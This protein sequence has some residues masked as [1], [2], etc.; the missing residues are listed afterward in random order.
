[1]AYFWKLQFELESP[2]D[3]PP[4]SLTNGL[5]PRADFGF[6]TAAGQDQ[7]IGIFQINVDQILCALWNIFAALVGDRHNI[8]AIF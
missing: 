5:R 4:D 7:L 8:S 3:Q 6:S 2:T 1:M